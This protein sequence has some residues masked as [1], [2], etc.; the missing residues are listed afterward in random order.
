MSNN[1]Q[2]HPPEEGK[3]EELTMQEVIH[4]GI[5]F[6]QQDRFSLSGENYRSGVGFGYSCG[7]QDGLAASGK[8]E[9][10]DICVEFANIILAQYKAGNTNIEQRPLM[11]ET[12]ILFL[13]AAKQ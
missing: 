11:T 2:P 6:A 7:Y 1:I 5:A 12:A 3:G 9:S 10:I 4:K 8:Q 13:K